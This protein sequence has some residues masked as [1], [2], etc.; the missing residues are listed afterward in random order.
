MTRAA[1]SISF[2]T[3]A[4]PGLGAKKPQV[5][6]DFLK[7]RHSLFLFLKLIWTLLGIYISEGLL[8]E[9][10]LA[11]CYNSLTLQPGQSGGRGSNPTSTLSVM[12]R[13][14]RLD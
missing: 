10:V 13:G 5:L 9:G 3:A 12:T 7:A 8:C 1:D 14:R 4:I 6:K 11:P 2:A